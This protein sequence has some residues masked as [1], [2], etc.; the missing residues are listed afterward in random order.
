VTA[1][2]KQKTP[3][4]PASPR[5]AD[6]AKLV[7]PPQRDIDDDAEDRQRVGVQDLNAQPHDANTVPPMVRAGLRWMLLH[8]IGAWQQRRPHRDHHHRKP[9]DSTSG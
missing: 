1:R 9:Y 7:Q 6:I 4:K 2:A 8:S 3:E 5:K